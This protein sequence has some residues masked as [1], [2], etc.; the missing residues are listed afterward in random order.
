MVVG[1]YT[2][3]LKVT[4]RGGQTAV[5]KV[6]VVVQPEKNTPPVA[7]AGSDKVSDA[8]TWVYRLQTTVAS[9]NVSFV[10]RL[11]ASPLC[12]PVTIRLVTAC[13]SC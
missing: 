8:C 2:F 11:A 9:A 3:M 4:D 12:G 1:D 10:I 6:T 13:C 7:R 5:S